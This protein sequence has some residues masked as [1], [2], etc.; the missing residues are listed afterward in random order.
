MNSLVVVDKN[1]IQDL[2]ERSVEKAVWKVMAR[3]PKNGTI[4][5]PSHVTQTQAAEILKLSRATVNKLVKNG[6]L[7]L[8]ACGM[9]PMTQ[10]DL[11]LGN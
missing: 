11:A 4:D 10:L 1:E 9:I 6:S 5:R 3:M 2:I 7:K 8:N